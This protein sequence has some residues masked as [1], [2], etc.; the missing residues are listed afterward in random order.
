MN[1]QLKIDAFHELLNS[2]VDSS[3][4]LDILRGLREVSDPSEF[5][6]KV[7][8]KPSAFGTWSGWSL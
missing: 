8:P 6:D 7:N 5:T 2:E 1:E 3:A 4:F